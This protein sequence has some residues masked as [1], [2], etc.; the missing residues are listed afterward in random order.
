MCNHTWGQDSVANK[1]DPVTS[2][3]IGKQSTRE[4]LGGKHE[5]YLDQ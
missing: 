5:G 4:D 3:Y 1:S 2:K